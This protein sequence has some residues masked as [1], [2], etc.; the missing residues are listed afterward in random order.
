MYDKQW[1][2]ALISR[3]SSERWAGRTKPGH[4]WSG[5]R[6]F[7]VNDDK[8]MQKLYDKMNEIFFKTDAPQ[9]LPN[10]YRLYNDPHDWIELERII[11]KTN[12]GLVFSAA[13]CGE[14]LNDTR[15]RLNMPSE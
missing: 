2:D 15:E 12:T 9:P 3:F 1:D 14:N 11:F 5:D 6:I 13:G 10:F 8:D 7:V 4:R